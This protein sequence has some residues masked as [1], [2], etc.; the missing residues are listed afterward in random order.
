[1]NDRSGKAGRD[2]PILDPRSTH[3]GVW[4]EAVT[5]H[6]TFLNEAEVARAMSMSA[7][8]PLRMLARSILGVFRR[9][10]RS[11]SVPAPSGTHEA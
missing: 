1:M 10:G 5:K 11:L 4:N 6:Q 7:G 3:Y 8:K 2:W 9:G